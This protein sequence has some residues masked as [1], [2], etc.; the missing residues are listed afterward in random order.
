MLV[1]YV[2]RIHVRKVRLCSFSVPLCVPLCLPLSLMAVCFEKKYIYIVHT[3][4]QSIFF[5]ECISN[6]QTMSVTAKDKQEDGFSLMKSN[7]IRHLM[8]HLVVLLE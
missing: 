3:K 8:K 4:C 7:K 5:Y 1:S 6:F 2:R